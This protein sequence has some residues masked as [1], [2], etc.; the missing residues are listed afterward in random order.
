MT[1]IVCCDFC[2]VRVAHI[3]LF[4]YLGLGCST[5][6]GFGVNFN[7]IRMN[8]VY[9]TLNQMTI[10]LGQTVVYISPPS[11]YHIICLYSSWCYARDMVLIRFACLFS[12]MRLIAR[13]W[14]D[15]QRHRH[16]FRFRFR[17]QTRQKH[18]AE[19]SWE[20]TKTAIGYSILHG[21]A[22]AAN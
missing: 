9:G 19:L 10:N 17:C 1:N 3:S 20:D 4:S 7:F 15:D 6:C 5:V 8:S 22:Y 16:T 11:D 12:K 21:V 2:N 18:G 14:N 13:S